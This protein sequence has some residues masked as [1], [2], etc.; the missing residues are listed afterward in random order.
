[1][2]HIY[3]RKQRHQEKDWRAIVDFHVCTAQRARLELVKNFDRQ[4]D[5][6]WHHLCNPIMSENGHVMLLHHLHVCAKHCGHGHHVRKI[7]YLWHY[8]AV[9]L[10]GHGVL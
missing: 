3:N 6:H 1:M 4:Y 5:E 2:L 7:K 10:I 8:S 9:V